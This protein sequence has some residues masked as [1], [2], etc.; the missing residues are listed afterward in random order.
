MTDSAND[1]YK[2][3]AQRQ[4]TGTGSHLRLVRPQDSQPAS[5][6]LSAATDLRV[7]DVVG[8]AVSAF[9]KAFELPA[10][11]LKASATIARVQELIA[12][13]PVEPGE[14]HPAQPLL[15]Q[16]PWPLTG[17]NLLEIYRAADK[18]GRRSLL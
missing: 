14:E 13:G 2:L 8:V 11:Q 10:L 5:P 6:E 17:D 1:H 4:G 7:E 12:A 16:G 18:D 3:N 9:L 15:E